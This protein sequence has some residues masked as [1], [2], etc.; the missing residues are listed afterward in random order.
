[1]SITFKEHKIKPYIYSVKEC[2]AKVSHTHLQKN[3]IVH[4]KIYLFIFV[5][6]ESICLSK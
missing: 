1:M 3:Y 4:L 5:L 6:L 2:K